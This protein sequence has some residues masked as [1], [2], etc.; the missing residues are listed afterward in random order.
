MARN[1]VQVAQQAA[2]Q[3]EWQAEGVGSGL[4]EAAYKHNK[5]NVVK[6]MVA[7]KVRLSS[8]PPLSL[9]TLPPLLAAPSCPQ[10]RQCSQARRHGGV[11]GP[12]CQ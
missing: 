9:L 6:E 2:W 7:A 4:D 8:L 3:A 10:H 12:V 1:A 11:F 5:R